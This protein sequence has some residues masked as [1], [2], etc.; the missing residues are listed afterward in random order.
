MVAPPH[1]DPADVALPGHADRHRFAL[2]IQHIDL[3]IRD[4]PPDGHSSGGGRRTGPGGDVD[5]G[6]RGAIEVMQGDLRQ[7]LLHPR[8]QRSRQGFAATEHLPEAPAGLDAGLVD[9][10]L[11]HGRDKVQGGD[12]L[13][14][15]MLDQPGRVLVGAGLGHDQFGADEQRPEEF[16]HGDVEADR[17]LLED[18][19]RR[20]QPIGLLHPLEPVAEARVAVAGAFRLP[21]GAG[22]VEDIGQLR[23]GGRLYR[24]GR[25]IPVEGGAVPIQA[26]GRAVVRQA[27]GLDGVGQQQRGLAVLQHVPQ[28]LGGIGRIQGHEGGARVPGAEQR[29]DQIHRPFQRHGD[30]AFRADAARLE[31]LG[32]SGRLRE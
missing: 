20:R 13:L 7:Q 23:S 18:A 24:R 14:H 27:R 10:G 19:V 17:G 3:E 32:E 29:H 6:F 4:G 16:P 25:G 15:D 8:R 21:G 5:G 9:E 1:P 26:E 22:G 12:A 28:P 2:G 30:Q 11:Q 31:R